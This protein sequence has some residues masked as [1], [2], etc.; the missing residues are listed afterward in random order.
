M[1]VFVFC[2][3]AGLGFLVIYFA[4]VELCQPKLN[5]VCQDAICA[6]GIATSDDAAADVLAELQFEL[7]RVPTVWTA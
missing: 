6:V 4:P 3:D 2:D 1:R 5:E 7:R